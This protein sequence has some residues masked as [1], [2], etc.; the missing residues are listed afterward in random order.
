MDRGR[1]SGHIAATGLVMALLAIG[2][3]LAACSPGAAGAAS[4]TTESTLP[5]GCAEVPGTGQVVAVGSTRV[6]VLAPRDWQVM[7]ALAGI[8]P[9]MGPDATASQGVV[10]SQ[11]DPHLTINVLV[12]D[13]AAL[14]VFADMEDP[15]TGT[16]LVMIRGIGALSVDRIIDGSRTGM[17]YLR[18]IGSDAVRVVAL[19]PE[20]VCDATL[21][22]LLGLVI[23]P[24]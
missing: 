19:G 12:D 4:P 22:A 1:A 10:V 9:A 24:P 2:S 18:K 20:G 3:T 23:L 13:A 11:Q 15:P 5:A 21:V 14:E 6:G 7:L 8:D 16:A 17:R